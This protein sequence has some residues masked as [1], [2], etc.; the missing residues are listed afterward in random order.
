GVAGQLDHH[1]V[2]PETQAQTGDLVLTG[3]A[4]GRDLALDPPPAEPAG[5]HH[6]VEVVQATLGQQTLDL[7]GLDPLDL[8]VGPVVVAAVLESLD[9]RQI[10]VGEVDVL[11]DEADAHGGGGRLDAAN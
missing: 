11:A 8:D 10:G 3:V 6:A 1:D 5:N 7:L 9:H 4:G 2:Q